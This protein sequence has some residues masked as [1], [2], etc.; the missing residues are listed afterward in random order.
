[1]EEEEVIRNI[2]HTID[3]LLNMSENVEVC[4]TFAK[5]RSSEHYNILCSHY[6]PSSNPTH[7]SYSDCIEIRVYPNWVWI[8]E[9]GVKCDAYEYFLDKL[10]QREKEN[11]MARMS[12]LVIEL[13]EKMGISRKVKT[14]KIL[15]Q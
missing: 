14:A 11:T 1:M 15:S 3:T 6:A 8:G 9:C 5:I 2:Y 4:Y 13:Q 7:S 10:R 12:H